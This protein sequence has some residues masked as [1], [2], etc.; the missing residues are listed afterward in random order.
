MNKFKY[1]LA[2][3]G[4][5]SIQLQAQKSVSFDELAFYADVMVN[6]ANEKNRVFALEKFNNLFIKEIDKKESFSNDFSNIKTISNLKADDASFRIFTWQIKKDD[7]T[8]LQ[9]GLIQKANGNYQILKQNNA[10]IATLGYDEV[11]AQTWYGALYYNMMYDQE[12]KSYL[13]FGLNAA[14][15]NTY[16]KVADVISF[17]KNEEVVFGK[18]IFRYDNK[19]NRPDLRTR[20]TVG[21]APYTSVNLSYNIDEKMIIHDYTTERSIGI[22]GNQSGL[23]PDGTYVAYKPENGVWQRIAQLENTA[24]DLMSPDYKTKRSTNTPD[25]LGRTKGSSKKGGG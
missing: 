16:Y 2:F 8:Y 11:N 4:I 7:N 23:V 21:Y 18:E 14:D 22:Q 25:I 10:S 24:V 3:L 19:S 6:A 20:I 1:I 12:S 13:I 15:A 17:D 5:F 9:N